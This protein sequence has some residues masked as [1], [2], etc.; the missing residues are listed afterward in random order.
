MKKKHFFAFNRGTLLRLFISGIVKY[1]REFFPILKM[2]KVPLL[3]AG[4]KKS[5]CKLNIIIGNRYN[6]MKFK[7]K[8]ASLKI[9]F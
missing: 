7:F 6:Q 3:Y 4:S 1:R 5:R 2:K 8:Q 9:D